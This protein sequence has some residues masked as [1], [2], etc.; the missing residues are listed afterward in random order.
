MNCFVFDYMWH[1]Y[2]IR[3]EP[4]SPAACRGCTPWGT[5]KWRGRRR[6]SEDSSI[7]WF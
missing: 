7:W 2:F 5:G 4:T 3:T 6:A 1:C